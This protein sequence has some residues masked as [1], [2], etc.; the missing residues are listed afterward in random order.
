VQN[1]NYYGRL[2]PILN[3]K[4]NITALLIKESNSMILQELKEMEQRLRAHITDCKR[5]ILLE[6]KKHGCKCKKLKVEKDDESNANE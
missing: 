3:K 6:I 1:H 5:L 2:T 4:N